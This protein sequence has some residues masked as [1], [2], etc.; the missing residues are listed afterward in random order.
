MDYLFLPMIFRY[1]S[2][3]CISDGLNEQACFQVPTV[4]G[5]ET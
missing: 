5:K 3:S 1:N 4:S 2:I